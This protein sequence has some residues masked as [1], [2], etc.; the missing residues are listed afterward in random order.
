MLVTITVII[1]GILFGEAIAL[2]A[3]TLIIKKN[4]SK[5][6]NRKN[7][8][9]L[10]LDIVTATAIILSLPALHYVPDSVFYLFLIIG[11]GTHI[12]RS[13]EYYSKIKKKF[14]DNTSLF[15]VNNIKLAGLLVILVVSVYG[16]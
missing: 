13:W 7:A 14:C 11:A 8:L 3:G 10:S 9:L 16:S 15:I 6:L 2:M 5:W 4:T 12:Y 1:C